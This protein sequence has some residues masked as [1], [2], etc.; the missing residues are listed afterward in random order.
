MTKFRK[1]EKPQSSRR[2]YELQTESELALGKAGYIH[3]YVQKQREDTRRLIV[4]NI[5]LKIKT[6]LTYR[7]CMTS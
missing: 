4:N 7:L 3:V 6:K 5:S 2:R 1:Q